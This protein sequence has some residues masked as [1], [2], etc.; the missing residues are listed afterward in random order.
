MKTWEEER[1]AAEEWAFSAV[2]DDEL[3]LAEFYEL[4]RES[5]TIREFQSW[6]A[7][8]KK[9]LD[10]ELRWHYLTFLLQKEIPRGSG[11]IL[12]FKKRGILDIP[13]QK[14][15][16]RQ[17]A[18]FGRWIPGKTAFTAPGDA[19]QRVRLGDMWK[20]LDEKRPFGQLKWK[21]MIPTPPIPRRHLMEWEDPDAR[22]IQDGLEFVAMA[23]D[24][25]NFRPSEIKAAMKGIVDDLTPPQGLNIPGQRGGDPRVSLD[26]IG[27]MR[28]MAHYLLTDAVLFA[29][30]KEADLFGSKERSRS[31]HV[32]RLWR[33]ARQA[34]IDRFHAVFPFLPD[35]RLLNEDTFRTRE[36]G[37]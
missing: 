29:Q 9:D 25:R 19:A 28:L 1:I 17:K 36:K 10:S 2:P 5:L 33:R 32:H 31:K 22:L 37:H 24:W 30:G 35:E 21:G 23:V 13:W 27:V 4:C 11:N 6:W 26:R 18:Q 34:A 7:S 16:G 20:R 15:T 14:L 8:K 12:G 3:Q